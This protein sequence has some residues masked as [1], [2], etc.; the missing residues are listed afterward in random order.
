MTINRKLAEQMMEQPYYVVT[1]DDIVGMHLC[2]WKDIFSML[3]NEKII[4]PFQDTF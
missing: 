3:F 4:K 2:T 1:K